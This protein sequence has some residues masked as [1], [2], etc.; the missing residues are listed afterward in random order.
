MPNMPRPAD[1]NDRGAHH[2]PG[3]LALIVAE[4]VIGAEK[5]ARS[6]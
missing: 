5:A 1:F 3:R 6:E 2:L 4:R